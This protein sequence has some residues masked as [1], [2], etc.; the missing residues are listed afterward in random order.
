MEIIFKNVSY[1]YNYHAPMQF[2]ALK[3]IDLQI[4]EGSFTSIIGETGSGKS[5][6][7]QHLNGLLI[8]SVGSVEIGDFTLTPD[9]KKK[10]LGELRRHVGM[11]FQ[12]PENQLYE[13][14]VVKDIAVAPIN[15]GMEE[16]AAYRTALE[17]LDLVELP[18]SLA[19]RSPFSLSG[20]QMRRVAIAG[21]LAMHPQILVLD[22]PTAGL[23]PRAHREMMELFER[24]HQE[25]QLTVVMV[26]HQMDDVAKYSD[27]VILLDQ[28]S[29]QA[30]GTPR[31]VFTQS[32]HL[33]VGYP[34]ALEFAQKLKQKG[35]YLSEPPL[36]T[37]ELVQELV[38][39]LT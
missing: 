12:F 30:A 16:S 22:E 2:R 24:L 39:K 20:G 13:A 23:D 26:T 36:S 17:M 8:P 37:T 27:Q 6:L 3:E 25:W 33:T 21:I 35:V 31:E 7:I 1:Y 28:G 19:D 10:R 11:V 9:T 4:R 18:K 32:D 34:R 5:T 29:I 14:T 38:R 15:Y